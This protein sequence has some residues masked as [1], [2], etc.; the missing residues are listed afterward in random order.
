MSTSIQYDDE[1]SQR[2]LRIYKTPDVVAQ[3]EVVL[4]MLKLQ[5]GERVLDIG[6]GPGLLSRSMAELVGESGSVTGIDVSAAM[7]GLGQQT[8]AELSQ[9]RIQEGDAMQLPFAD[10]VFD[11]AVSTQVYEYIS[12]VPVALAELYRVLRPGGRALVLDTDWDTLVWNT[13]DPERMARILKAFEKHCSYPRLPRTLAV[14]LRA[15]GFRVDAVNVYVLLNT[16]YDE[17]TYTHGAIDFIASYLTNSSEV[18][19][20]DV[21]AWATELRQLGEQDAYFCSNNRYL[22]LAVKE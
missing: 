10:G 13:N 2:I 21:E 17:N 6:S 16:K 18:L 9:V 22:F 14:Q 11:V 8:C 7:I 1:W 3:R 5:A 20:D 15:A 12:D 4:S 19:Q